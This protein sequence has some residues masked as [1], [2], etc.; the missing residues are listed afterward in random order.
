MAGL[1][2]YIIL[3][4]AAMALSAHSMPQQTNISGEFVLYNH[5]YFHNRRDCENTSDCII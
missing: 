3:L 4:F 1:Q 5:S 2:G